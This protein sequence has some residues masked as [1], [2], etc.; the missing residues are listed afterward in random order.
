MNILYI[1]AGYVGTCSA[2]VAGDSG[3]ETLVYEI[4]KKRIVFSTQAIMIF[5][6]TD[7]QMQ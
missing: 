7:P 2:A 6:L 4:D 5:L 3:H 1:G